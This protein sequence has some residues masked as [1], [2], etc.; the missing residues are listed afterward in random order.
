MRLH[1]GA[2]GA[3]GLVTPAATQPPLVCSEPA[4]P[5]GPAG[6]KAGLRHLPAE[7][8]RCT[9]PRGPGLRERGWGMRVVRFVLPRDGTW[10][11]ESCEQREFGAALI[12]RGTSVW[13]GADCSGKSQAFKER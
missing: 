4:F 12:E 11:E 5:A 8:P 3:N 7:T 2:P 9:R 6:W 10:W 13:L 1:R